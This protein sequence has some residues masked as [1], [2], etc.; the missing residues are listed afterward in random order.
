MYIYIYYKYTQYTQHKYLIHQCI[1]SIHTQYTCKAHIREQM[2]RWMDRW[3]MYIYT[4]Y[5]HIQYTYIVYIDSI[6]AEYSYTVY[7]HS[8]Y[9]VYMDSRAGNKYFFSGGYHKLKNKETRVG[10]IRHTFVSYACH[11]PKLASRRTKQRV[12][13][14]FISSYL[15]SS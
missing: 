13:K 10:K 5:I 7:L 8:I 14:I 15:S 11:A 1:N 9:I 3:S 4:M 2:D 6:H 12:P